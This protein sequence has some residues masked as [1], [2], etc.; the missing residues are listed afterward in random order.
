MKPS[1][2]SAF[3]IASNAFILLPLRIVVGSQ[4]WFE[5]GALLVSMAASVLYHICDEGLPCILPLEALHYTDVLL[6]YAVNHSL[7]VLLN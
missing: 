2:H 3:V 7:L 4:Q 1:G 5:A 6:M